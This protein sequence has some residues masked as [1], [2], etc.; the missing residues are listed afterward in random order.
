M[1]KRWETHNL[2]DS[3]HN[4]DQHGSR[5][6]KVS[7]IDQGSASDLDYLFEG[8]EIEDCYLLANL[9][10]LAQRNPRYIT[11][12]LIKKLVKMRLK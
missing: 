5:L 12:E 8:S 11:S 1:K 3:L 10:G 6:P 4:T 7:D 2:R 9:M